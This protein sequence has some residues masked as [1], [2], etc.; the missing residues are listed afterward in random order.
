MFTRPLGGILCL[1]NL[2]RSILC[3]EVLI[4]LEV[5]VEGMLRRPVGD[6]LCFEDL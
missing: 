3:F 2:L 4:C 5:L 6:L 1:E